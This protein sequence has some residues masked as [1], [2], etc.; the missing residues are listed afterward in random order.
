MANSGAAE[1]IVY[2]VDDDES[3]RH[4]LEFLL[5]VAGIRV[6]SFPNADAFLK[7]SPP[8]AGACIVTDVRMPGTG[9][10]ELVEELHRRGATAPVIVITGHADVP[11]AIQAMKAGVAD[12]IEKPFDDQVMLEAIRSALARNAGDQQAQAERQAVLDRMATLSPREREVV[13]GLVA[14]KANKVIAFDLDISA[15]TVEVYRANAMMKM[16]ARTL[17]DLVR[18]VT[19]ATLT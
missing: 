3:A 5:D 8:L 15:R 1:P 4:S 2:V 9:G 19:L 12:F 14:G 16:Q 17:S 6:R 7:S 11:L 18:M 13:V 10:I